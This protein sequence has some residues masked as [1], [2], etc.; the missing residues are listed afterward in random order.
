MIFDYKFVFNTKCSQRELPTQYSKSYLYSALYMNLSMNKIKMLCICS[1]H[2][3]NGLFA[4][5]LPPRLLQKR[6]EKHSIWGTPHKW[7]TFW[8][9]IRNARMILWIFTNSSSRVQFAEHYIDPLDMT[10]KIPTQICM[11]WTLL[12]VK[13]IHIRYPFDH[14]ATLFR[15]GIRAGKISLLFD[16]PQK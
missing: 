11:P 15:S 12:N 10:I 2:S 3:S 16:I 4:V 1:K 5:A 9:C 14:L 7:W 13:C 8:I 6:T